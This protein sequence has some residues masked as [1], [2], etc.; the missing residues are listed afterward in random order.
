MGAFGEFF[1]N[2]FKDGSGKEYVPSAIE[3]PSARPT[4]DRLAD[5]L[6][7]SGWDN[8]YGLFLLD[9]EE[10][11]ACEG[12]GFVLEMY[13]QTGA[14]RDMAELLE[15]LFTY[16]PTGT[17]VQWTL[18]ATPLVDAFL[19][20]FVTMRPDP[21]EATTQEE[22]DT[23]RLYR[24]L[25]TG[26]A[27]HYWQGSMKSVLANQPY[28]LREFRLIMSVVVPAKDKYDDVAKRNAQSLRETC[29]TA[30]KTY[31]QYDRTWG[32]DDLI[33]WCDLMLNPH[34]TLLKHD[35]P[36]LN[37][38]KSRRMREQ[39]I[40]HD[41]VTRVTENGLLYGLPQHDNEIMAVCMSMRSYPKATTLHAMGQIIG[42]YLQPSIGYNCPY[43]ITMGVVT[44]DF[45]QTRAATQMKAARATQ[46]AESPMARF[47]PELQ[48]IKHDWDIANKSYDSGTGTVKL[49]HQVLLWASPEEAARAEQGVQAVWR[50]QRF[51]LC[52]DT[53]VQIQGLLS[54]LPLMLTRTFQ[55]DLKTTQ[56]ISTKTIPNAINMAPL[57]AEWT[58]VGRPVIPMW[59][60]RGQAMSID[61][62]A[63]ESG[64]YNGIVVGT[65][66]SG[67]SAFLV[68][69]VMCYLSVGARIWII[70]IGHSYEALCRTV[71]GQYIEFTPET[72]IRINPWQM[73]NNIEE[74]LEM[75][76]PLFEQM[77]SPSTPLEE[78]QRRALALHVQ[79]IWYE[80]G[81]AATIDDLMQSL[82]NNCEKGGPNPHE[83]DPEWIEQVRGMSFEERQKVCDPRIRDIGMQL[84]PYSSGG[85]Y[86]RYFSGDTNINF[87]SDL[88]VL[89]LESLAQRKDLQATVMYMLIYLITHN[90]YQTRN[91]KKICVLDEAWA[92]LKG[93]TGDFI[94]TGFRRARKYAASFLVATQGV[95]DFGISRAAEAAFE[96]ADWMFLLRQKAESIYALKKSEK[97]VMDEEMEK[98]LLSVK[99]VHGQYSEVFV[100]AGQMGR[101][102]GRVLMDPFF[103]LLASSK[104][105]DYEAVRAYTGQGMALVDALNSVLA[106]RGVPGF[107]HANAR[108]QNL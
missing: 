34:R 91:R 42:D 70:D 102:I 87:D 67:K 8:D 98:T 58:G 24:Q 56:R 72:D 19:N 108:Q 7:Y 60:R 44:Q 84:F 41:T 36:E 78:F 75:L 86:G 104:A 54:S 50:A 45:E 68:Y 85:A 25:V 71:G 33:R 65:S 13:P 83:H 63:N 59:G 107:Q 96:N 79:S 38:D 31:Y 3:Y 82:I 101:G 4:F 43:A 55:R 90:M 66:G 94:E 26:L 27:K 2:F 74:D 11:D 17:G 51:E 30:L 14:S 62:F 6:P 57:I 103:L 20:D 16:M 29:I 92:L 88:I 15:T 5:V 81:N 80:K 95:N 106:D 37:Y 39:V 46:K 77:I 18:M 105:E 52:Q 73:V 69:L 97:L 32:P 35:I 76:V 99:T 48:D 49:Y 23:K 10:H 100:S 9:G 89:E 40:A 93:G 61:L 47:M 53:Y 28:L 21:D 64:N 22:F 1:R 12:V